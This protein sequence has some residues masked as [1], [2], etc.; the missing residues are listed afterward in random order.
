MSRNCK[1]FVNT[2]GG[3]SAVLFRNQFLIFG[4]SIVSTISGALLVLVTGVIAP[5]SPSASSAMPAVKKSVF[6][7]PAAAPFAS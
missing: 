2:T 1:Q 4:L 3:P 5:N 7:G 6:V